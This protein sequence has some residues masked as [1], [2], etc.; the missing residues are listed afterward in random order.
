M[1]RPFHIKE[2][3]HLQRIEQRHREEKRLRKLAAVATREGTALGHD[4]GPFE[5]DSELSQSAVATCRTC[6]RFAAVD[7]TERPY[8]FGLVYRGRCG[9]KPDRR[10]VIDLGCMTVGEMQ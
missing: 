6:G 7:W 4:L 9:E 5:P 10:T 2:Y 8:L 3:P 1:V